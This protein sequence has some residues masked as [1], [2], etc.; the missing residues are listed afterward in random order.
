[1]PAPHGGPFA[2]IRT[3]N[4]KSRFSA[5]QEHGSEDSSMLFRRHPWHDDP[6]LR[7]EELED[8]D[9]DED[10]DGFDADADDEDEDEDDDEDL[11]EDDLEDDDL[12]DEDDD[13]DEDDDDE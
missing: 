4:P 8:E 11:E 13:E 2:I 12:D 10:D 5:T 1:M 3:G 6:T 7:H 9:D